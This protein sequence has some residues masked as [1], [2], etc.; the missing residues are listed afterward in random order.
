MIS[1]RTRTHAPHTPR[2]R[3]AAVLASPELVRRHTSATPSSA[4]AASARGV[5]QRPQGRWD[6]VIQ[7][8]WKQKREGTK[9]LPTPMPNTITGGDNGIAKTW[10]RRE[11]SASSY[12]DPSQREGTK[13]LPARRRHQHQ[14]RA[15]VE[16][17]LLRRGGGRPLL[18]A[19][20]QRQWRRHHGAGRARGVPHS[21]AAHLSTAATY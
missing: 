8:E 1:T 11:I 2:R 12:D 3:A 20:T 21:A 4:D 15:R 7:K 16:H 5:S 10:N 14:A 9:H 17:Q 18:L 13:H 19:A 6:G